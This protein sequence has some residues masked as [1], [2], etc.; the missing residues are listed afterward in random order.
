MYKRQAWYSAAVNWA[1][2]KAIVNGHGEGVFAPNDAITREQL[3]AILYRY[4]TYKAYDTTASGNIDSFTDGN[5]AADWAQTALIWAA[6]KGI[7]QGDE[8]G[9]LNPT[10][11]ATRAEVAQM[12]LNF[13]KIIVK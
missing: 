1:A 11:T 12:L 9:L 8:A 13:S 4:A 10:G 3:A 6:D 7:M 2:E 5:A